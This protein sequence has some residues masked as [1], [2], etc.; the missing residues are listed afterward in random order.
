MV[1]GINHG[2]LILV[3]THCG[4]LELASSPQVWLPL[5]TDRS[6]S[7]VL[8]RCMVGGSNGLSEQ[9]DLQATAE[10]LIHL[11]GSVTGTE[12]GCQV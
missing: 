1:P 7:L 10:A 2:I 4:S 6:D 3:V 12:V 5:G 9:G 8:R 11:L